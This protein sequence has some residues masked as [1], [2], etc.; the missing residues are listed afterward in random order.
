MGQDLNLQRG[1]RNVKNNVER[2]A[3][4][5]TMSPWMEALLRLGYLVRGVVYGVI[6]LLALQAA[7]GVGGTLTDPK[8]AIAAI[9]G[10]PLGGILLYII[11]VGL[12]S[13]GLWG[14]IRAIVDNRVTGSK[15][16]VERIGYAIS[17]ISYLVLGLAVYNPILGGVAPAQNGS[18]TSQ[19]QQATGTILSKPWGAWVVALGGLIIVA[20]G[21]VQISRGLHPGLDKQLKPYALSGSER[22]W[23]I[24]L[25]RLGLPARGIVFALIGLFLILAAATNNP[26]QAK[27]IDGVLASLL[28]QPFGPWLLAIVALGL[29]AFGLYSAMSGV[30]LRIRR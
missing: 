28:H 14:L 2:A 5:A 15:G 13:Y 18:Q 6:G 10:T 19:I 9:G 30:W 22:R 4:Q 1:A 12:L 17:G 16:I 29:I 27:G 20:V 21:L 3:N 24:R 7:L 25:G 26:S 11:L 8:G 23:I